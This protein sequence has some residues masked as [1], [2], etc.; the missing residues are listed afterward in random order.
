[1]TP[2]EAA[3]VAEIR[4]AHDCEIHYRDVTGS[5]N[6][7]AKELALQGCASGAVA[8]AGRQEAGRGRQGRV[9]HSPEGALA[10]TVVLRER[11]PEAAPA[12]VIPA[13]SLAVCD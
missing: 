1:M 3:V 9:W 2:S 4:S 12:T 6:D 8:V 7:W 5:T 10:F 11:S 13:F